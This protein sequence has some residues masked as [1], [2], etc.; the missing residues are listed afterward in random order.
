MRHL[1]CAAALCLAATPS[2][3]AT[4][5]SRLEATAASLRDKA[6]TGSEAYPLLESLT[7]EVGPRLA[8]TEA[9]HRAALWAVAKMKA[10]GFQNVHVEAFSMPQWIR[11]E[12]RA[13]VLSPF[14]QKLAVTALG[15]SATT[16]PEGIEA[17]I[18]LFK[19]YDDLLAQPVGALKGKIAVVTQPMM[20]AQ[21]GEGYGALVRMRVAGPSEAAKR[22]AVAFLIRSLATDDRRAPHTGVT[23]YDPKAFKIPAGALSVPDAE[24]LDHM[25]ARGLPLRLKLVLVSRMEERGQSETVVGEIVGRE[26]PDEIVLIGGHLD[27]WDLGQGAIDDGAGVAATMA[28][29]KL[30]ADLPQH[31]RRTL[32]VALFGAEE[33]GETHAPFAKAHAAELDKHVIASECDFGAAPVYRID[34]PAGAVS[35]PYGQAL[36][37][38]TARLPAVLGPGPAQDGGADLVDLTGVPLAGLAQDGTH[39][40]DLHHTADDTLDKVDAKEMDRLT[41]AWVAF[42]Y[43]AADSDVDFRALA[44]GATETPKRRR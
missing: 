41:A 22:G 21:D 28:A 29:A 43:L 2:L 32:R 12:E 38:V 37:N 17:E 1:F 3:A 5:W 4:D 23:H 14:P 36:A 13:E 20:K 44:K 25:S 15:L 24:L 27:S 9:E 39:Y 42:A 11:G 6:L 19:T 33:V 8:A 34:L 18:A 31:P 26:R 40:F 16:P 35:S 30:I 10:L 7:T